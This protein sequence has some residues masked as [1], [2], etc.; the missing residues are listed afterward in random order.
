MCAAMFGQEEAVRLL[1]N[2]GANVEKR[3]VV[4]WV[5]LL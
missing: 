4:W 5:A 1:L 3:D 2:S